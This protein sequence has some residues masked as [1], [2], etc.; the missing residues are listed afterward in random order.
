MCLVC[1]GNNHLAEIDV[2]WDDEFRLDS[3]Q[4]AAPVPDHEVVGFA[5]C[6]FDYCGCKIT[7]CEI[8]DV[9]FVN[10]FVELSLQV[11]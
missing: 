4:S 9:P 2:A 1:C 3:V 11:F 5:F 8:R 7:A 10:P 6:C